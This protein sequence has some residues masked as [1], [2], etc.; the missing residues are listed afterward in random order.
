MSNQMMSNQIWLIGGTQESATLAASLTQAAIPFIVTVTTASA[1]RMYPEQPCAGIHV[2]PIPQASMANWLTHHGIAG[3]LDA[4]HPFATA[5][6]QGAIAAATQTQ[7]PYLRFER[8]VV[9]PSSPPRTDQ[10]D[11][12]PPRNVHLVP[13]LETLL[14]P[15]QL[16]GE[17]VLLVLGYRML[18]HFQPWQTEAQLF[19]RILP[20]AV[21]LEAALAA[22]F[23][24]DRLIA[25]RPP[26]S[27]ALEQALWQQ[28]NI[29]QVIAKCSGQAGGET[30]KR[31][32]A[33]ALDI[34]LWLIQRPAVDYPSQTGDIEQAIA[35]AQ[36][37][38]SQTLPCQAA[39][40]G[41]N[42]QSS[43]ARTPGDQQY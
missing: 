2:G 12:S 17:R 10:T 38:L 3:I 32:T 18:H 25:L 31:K 7:R 27:S 40:P 19:A 37:A 5:V 9:A 16:A 36:A 13:N 41:L 6:S 8:S 42:L 24:S 39:H 11:Q 28:W 29:T 35:F 33:A 15:A 1:R 4:S 14:T 30:T 22:G 26:V 21:A 23:T 43:G 20:S 34:P